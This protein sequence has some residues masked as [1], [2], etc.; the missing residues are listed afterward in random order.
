[1]NYMLEKFLSIKNKMIE[2]GIWFSDW[3][4]FLIVMS[5]THVLYQKVI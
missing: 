1:M 3:L 4:Q 5:L 2:F